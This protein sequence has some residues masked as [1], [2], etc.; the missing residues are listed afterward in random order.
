MMTQ[1]VP[2][3]I[4]WLQSQGANP[5]ANALAIVPPALPPGFPAGV[6]MPPNFP[7]PP[8]GFATPAPAA[9]VPTPPPPSPR[10]APKPL[11]QPALTFPPAPKT[12]PGGHELAPFAVGPALEAQLGTAS[13]VGP[14]T[15][16]LPAD[17]PRTS[18]ADGGTRSSW[19]QRQSGRRA[20]TTLT[21]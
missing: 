6:P 13:K 7:V 4:V 14:Y 9:P 18:G 8:P 2:R 12:D 19:T 10:P 16:R 15:L 21:V 20:T 5:P 17:F 3:G 1:G 11:E